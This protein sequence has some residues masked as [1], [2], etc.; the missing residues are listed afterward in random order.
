MNSGNS[1]MC[2]LDRLTPGDDA[3]PGSEDEENSEGELLRNVQR[4]AP[5]RLSLTPACRY[6]AEG[7]GTAAVTVHAW[8]GTFGFVNCSSESRAWRCC[9]TCST[10]PTPTP[11]TALS[12]C[13]DFSTTRHTRP[14]R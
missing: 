14:V 8:R 6:L 5:A 13:D 7:G 2:A 3:R 9:V 1:V 10:G 12:K 11:S 4:I